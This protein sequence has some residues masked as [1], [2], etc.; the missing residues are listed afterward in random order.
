MHFRIMKS[1]VTSIGATETDGATA[2][3]PKQEKAKKKKSLLTISS[4]SYHSKDLLEL[5]YQLASRLNP[6]FSFRWVV[7]ENT[8]VDDENRFLK[9]DSRFEVRAGVER[10]PPHEGRASY[11]HGR[12]LNRALKEVASRFLLVLDPDFFVLEENW[13]QK[14]L[15]YMKEEGL[16]FLGAPWHPRWY[17]KWRYF[18][19]AHCLF[20][21]LTKVE[22][23]ELDFR[24]EILHQL[25]PYAAIFLAEHEW[26]L[27]RGEH[28]K[29]WFRA[30]RH[31]RMTLEEDRRSRMIVGSSRDTGIHLFE[32]F[33]CRPGIRYETFVPVYRPYQDQLIP[34]PGVRIDSRS[35]LRELIER[36]RP[37]WLSFIPK[38]RGYFSKSGFRELWLPDLHGRG[39]E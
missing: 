37:D 25:W 20:I 8:P 7:V 34:P 18:P 27:A 33:S 22:L 31:L 10:P 4:V 28:F 6:G 15:E 19:C 12:A 3:S 30:L 35:T 26:M 36:L 9:T 11:H 13:M 29:A 17:R 39:W 21:D 2:G 14:I 24:P 5:N 16:A 23:A 32:R 1:T 38:R